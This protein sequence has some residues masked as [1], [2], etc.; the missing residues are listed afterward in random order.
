MTEPINFSWSNGIIEPPPNLGKYDIVPLH[1]YIGDSRVIS[2][3]KM[4]LAERLK[5]L[6]F[7]KVWLDVLAPGYEI[8]PCALTVDRGYRDD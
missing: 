4:S 1:V 2:C 3:W 8:H 6:L 7:G 5:A